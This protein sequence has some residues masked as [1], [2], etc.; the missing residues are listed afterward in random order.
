MTIHDGAPTKPSGPSGPQPSADLVAVP[1]VRVAHLPRHVR[2]ELA[3]ARRAL[4][5]RRPAERGLGTAPAETIYSIAFLGSAATTEPR[6]RGADFT[7]VQQVDGQLRTMVV[8]AK[9]APYSA[10]AVRA[11]LGV[12]AALNARQAILESRTVDGWKPAVAEF[13]SMWLGVPNPDTEWLEAVSTALLGSWVDLLDQH[14]VDD[15]GALGL[16]QLKR[17]SSV[18]HRQLQPLW[19][20]KAAGGRLLSLDHPVPGGGT[21]ID[22]LADRAAHDGPSVLWEPDTA[23]AACVFSQLSPDEQQVVRAWAQ[24][25]RA[26][27]AEA[28]DLAGVTAADADSV[29]RKL[30]RLGRRFEERT[31]AARVTRGSLT[32]IAG[33]GA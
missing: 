13:V 15:A 31:A 32:N 19:R 1:H 6:E 9:R 5:S 21:L 4:A 26:S 7:W 16:E 2:A 14:L 25:G 17:E 23:P 12:F 20:R 18:V 11:R 8:Q 27:W 24:S 30:R 22:V 28:A 10:E 3:A 29:R 33:S